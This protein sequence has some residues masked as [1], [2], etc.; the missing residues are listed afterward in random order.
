MPFRAKDERR[1]E[2]ETQEGAKPWVSTTRRTERR[3]DSGMGM[4]ELAAA[5]S[6]MSSTGCYKW[7]RGYG[8]TVMNGPVSKLWVSVIKTGDALR[9]ILSLDLIFPPFPSSSHLSQRL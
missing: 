5:L 1:K 8:G 3:K 2:V 7:G 4:R 9:S 6:C